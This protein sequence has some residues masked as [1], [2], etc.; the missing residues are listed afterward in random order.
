MQA[1]KHAVIRAKRVD[2]CPVV[3]ARS[4][5]MQEVALLRNPLIINGAGEGKRTLVI[6]QR[7]EINATSPDSKPYTWIQ[8]T[9]LPSDKFDIL[10]RLFSMSA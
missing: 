1:G 5:F 6:I 10:G 8:T 3:K 9:A 2:R 7:L 4:D